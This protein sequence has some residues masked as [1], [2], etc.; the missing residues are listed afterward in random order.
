VIVSLGL[1]HIDFVPPA[2]V[3]RLICQQ[4]LQSVQNAAAQ[5]IFNL[6]CS[7]H[8]TDALIS[9]HCLRILEHIVYK[10]A[11]LTFKVLLGSVPGYLRP[12]VR[13]ADLRLASC[14]LCWYQLL[15]GATLQA[16]YN[17]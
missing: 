11:I 2:T 17:W 4:W 6:W 9:L 16:V 10:I 12:V 15:V 13:V 5:L 7:D 8:I 3:G 1:A 14:Q